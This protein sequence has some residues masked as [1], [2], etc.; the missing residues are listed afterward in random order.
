MKTECP[1]CHQEYTV[2]ENQIGKKV[3]CKVCEKDF[4]VHRIQT[5]ELRIPQPQS[6][7]TKEGPRRYKVLVVKEGFWGSLFFGASKLP[8]RRMEQVLNTYSDQGFNLDFM[9]I[10]T[11]RH[12][13]FWTRE[14]AVMTLSKPA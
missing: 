5:P 8:I 10:E 1:Y 6:T 3:Q 7:K 2:R 11:Y 13:I 4:K 12:L 9:L 14:A